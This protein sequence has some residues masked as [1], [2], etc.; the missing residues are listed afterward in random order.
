MSFLSQKKEKKFRKKRRKKDVKNTET[1]NPDGLEQI[2]PAIMVLDYLF[3]SYLKQSSS[4]IEHPP[5]L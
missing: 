2:D 4:S 3:N 5:P 1:S